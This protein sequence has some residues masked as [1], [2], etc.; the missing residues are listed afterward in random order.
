MLQVGDVAAADGDDGEVAQG[1]ED[2]ALDGE[3]VLGCGRGLAADRD[4]LAEVALGE[5][6]EGGTGRLLHPGLGRVLAGAG[7]GDGDGRA[8]AGLCRADDAVAAEG[9][10]PRAARPP[11]L[12]DVDPGA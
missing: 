9:G 2:M 6:G 1:G 8:P 10:A 11:G 4:V 3:A 12:H 7:A 5:G